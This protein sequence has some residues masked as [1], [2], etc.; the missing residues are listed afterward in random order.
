MN[1]VR[2]T[3]IYLCVFLLCI[4]GALLNLHLPESYMIVGL[5]IAVTLLGLPHG[6]LDFAVAKSLKLISSFNSAL[7]FILVYTAISAFSIALWVGFPAT[8]LGL[9]FCVS[10]YHFSTDWRN[11][12]PRYAR[13]G[14]A[15][16]IICGSSIMYSSTLLTL[17]TLLFLTAE[18]ANLIIQG[19]QIMFWIGITAFA[20]F[21]MQ[22]LK[23]NLTLDKFTL[24]ECVALIVSSLT[25]TPLL[26]FALYFCLLHSPK[27]LNDVG[28]ELQLSVSKAIILSLPFVALTIVLAAI[29]FEFFG[30]NDVNVDLLRWIFIGLFGLTMSHMLLINLWHR[31]HR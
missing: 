15:S 25:L 2:Y 31:S 10:I 9:F 21:I 5:A 27:H 12:M 23:A 19:M 17:F 30:V 20:Y 4:I 16:I 24:V 1:K 28:E 29:L 13:L 14:M 22:L 7:Y 18:T 6:A 11:T 8:S 3:Q 26:H